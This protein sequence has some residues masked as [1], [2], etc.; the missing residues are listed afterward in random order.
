MKIIHAVTH[1][2]ARTHARRHTSVWIFDFQWNQLFVVSQC[3][4]SQL[5][6]R[7]TDP[8]VTGNGDN[9]PTHASS[10]L[11]GQREGTVMTS[12]GGL[13]RTGQLVKTRSGIGWRLTHIFFSQCG[14][15][16]SL[17]ETKRQTLLVCF[18]VR[19][20]LSEA[21]LR[22]G[23]FQRRLCVLCVSRTRTDQFH[24]L[25]EKRI[26]MPQP[27]FNFDSFGHHGSFLSADDLL[28]C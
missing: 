11:T 1:M 26:A 24:S 23:F 14:G 7:V 2:H 15:Q 13:I 6:G 8:R 20:D 19:L 22:W 12:E 21:Q 28:F 3:L 18:Q 27:Y 17:R 4:L 9:P 5:D 25:L 16:F 10:N